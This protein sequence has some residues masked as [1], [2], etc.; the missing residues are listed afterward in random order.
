M[1]KIT[2]LVFTLGFLISQVSM[3]MAA[4]PK[5]LLPIKITGQV[6]SEKEKGITLKAVQDDSLVSLN[7]DK[8]TYVIEA[9]TG[10][11]SDIKTRKSEEV[12]AYY[13][14]I[15]TR[16]IPPQSNAIAIFVNIPQDFLAPF[17]AK[18]EA[19]E[20]GESQ[21]KVT[22]NA[23]D[24]IVSIPND[25]P[26]TPYVTKNIITNKDIKVGSELALWY[27]AV[28]MSNPMQT[29][30]KK[31][32]VLSTQAEPITESKKQTKSEIIEENKI[33]KDSDI[34]KG[35]LPK[36]TASFDKEP[37]KKLNADIDAIYEKAIKTAKEMKSKDVT[38]SYEIIQILGFQNSVIIKSTIATANTSVEFINTMVVNYSNFKSVTIKTLKDV[39]GANA[40]KIANDVILDTIEKSKEGTYFTDEN[41]FKGLKSDPMFFVDINGNVII[42]FEKYAIAPGSTGTP[43]FKINISEVINTII[44]SDKTYMNKDIQMIPLRTV[45]EACGFDISWEDATKSIVVTKGT[46]TH[47]LIINKDLY[48]GK[49]LG[50][51]PQIKDGTTFVPISYF[52]VILGGSYTIDE[53]KYITIT[54]FE[55]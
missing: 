3:V 18:V 50:Q 21:V 24:M 37:I 54:F 40:Y 22:I 26:I 53:Q 14:P 1:K 10:L 32:V 34:A 19:V 9:E 47:K 55:K 41:A 35:E 29:T 45:A 23:G 36:F 8:S 38:F 20:V 27:G 15:T 39:L 13:G 6:E 43:M 11:P 17:Y 12:V 30:A 46:E 44:E 48:D 42:V 4:T 28:T 5:D 7:I 31:V 51:S 52:E 25:T 33:F 49:T 2:N 16:S